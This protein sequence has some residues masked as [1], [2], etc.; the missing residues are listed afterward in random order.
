MLMVS[1]TLLFNFNNHALASQNCY[2]V[3]QT[4]TVIGKANASIN[5][6]TYFPLLNPICVY[7]PKVPKSTNILST[8]GSDR[9]QPYVYLKITGV[10]HDGYERGIVGFD[11]DVKE[12]VNVD[13]EI[14]AKKSEAKESCRDWQI[15][16]TPIL[17][18]KSHG[19]NVGWVFDEEGSGQCFIWAVD[20]EIPH[21]SIYLYRHN[22]KK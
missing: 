14:N 21:K 13:D 1:T 12:A 2:K 19:N 4:I 15:K 22:V 5:G 18:T 20:K 3:G 7:Y 11:I 8:L 6:G 9:L 16:N 17:T 10:L